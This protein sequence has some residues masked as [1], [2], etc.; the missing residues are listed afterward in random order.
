[1]TS[2]EYSLLVIFE[3][4]I[5]F[6]FTCSTYYDI[7]LFIGHTFLAVLPGLETGTRGFTYFPGDVFGY[8]D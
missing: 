3:W 4:L 8:R 6:G 7:Y 5:G 2:S 1:M